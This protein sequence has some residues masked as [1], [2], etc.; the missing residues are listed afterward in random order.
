MQ[1]SESLFGVFVVRTVEDGD[2]HLA[3]LPLEK[4]VQTS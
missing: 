1:P 3:G 2:A 4:D